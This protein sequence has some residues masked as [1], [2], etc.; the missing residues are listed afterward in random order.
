MVKTSTVKRDLPIVKRYLKGQEPKAIAAQLG[1]P[2]TWRVYDAIK[3]F[4]SF[5]KFSQF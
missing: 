2:N 1:L 4:R 3:R 5:P